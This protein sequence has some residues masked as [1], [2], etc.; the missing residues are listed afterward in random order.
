MYTIDSLLD[1]VPPALMDDAAHKR[2][3]IAGDQLPDALAGT[4]CLEARLHR[5]PQVDLLV[6]A[7]RERQLAVLAGT[8][9]TI[10]LARELTE[11]PAWQGA[12]RM[13]RRCLGLAGADGGPHPGVWLEFDLDADGKP[14]TPG[15]FAAT[16]PDPERPEITERTVPTVADIVTTALGRPG[17]G[18]EPVADVARRIVDS[19]LGIGGVG[20]FP[21]R[22]DSGVR[23]CCARDAQ[24]DALVDRL[25]EAGW[26]G[27]QE[28]LRLW[29]GTCARWGDRIC[30]DLDATAEGLSGAIGIEVAFTGLPLPSEEPR[31]SGLLDAF[32]RAGVCTA[33]KRRAVEELGG[34]YPVDLFTRCWYQQRPLHTKITMTADGQVYA[35]IYFVSVEIA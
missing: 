17:T 29:L 26:P 20:V 18:P 28:E 21:G 6:L 34:R 16:T 7:V 14:L 30:V 12:A 9:R 1:A 24:P 2:L 31:W 22:P 15:F 25:R 10:R 3:R 32:Q 33:A 4:I 13:A 27:R 11:R 35:K 19:G 5:D 8:D 23:L